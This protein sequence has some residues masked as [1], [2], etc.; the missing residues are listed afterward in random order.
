MVE[1][2]SGVWWWWVCDG[3][4]WCDVE[5]LENGVPEWST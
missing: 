3:V 1:W 4:V 5:W 2:C